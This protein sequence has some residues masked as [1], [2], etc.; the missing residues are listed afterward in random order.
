MANADH[1]EAVRAVKE[2]KGTI[3]VVGPILNE[4]NVVISIKQRKRKEGLYIINCNQ[5]CVHIS[6]Y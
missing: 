6:V 1:R 2:S 4:M 5:I 3:A